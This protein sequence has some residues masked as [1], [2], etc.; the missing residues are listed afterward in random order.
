M[1]QMLY[2]NLFELNFK[3][4]MLRIYKTYNSVVKIY[5]Y[6]KLKF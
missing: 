3:F 2:N 4:N 6:V 1:G 5:N